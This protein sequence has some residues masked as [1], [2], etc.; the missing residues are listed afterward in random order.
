M[1]NASILASFI[2]NMYVCRF[3]QLM[4]LQWQR[5]QRVSFAFVCSI[6][7]RMRYMHPLLFLF[8]L[9]V[10][11]RAACV[12]YSI[13]NCLSIPSDWIHRILW[14]CQSEF[15]ML[16][17]ERVVT[18]VAASRL[19]QLSS[20]NFS[21]ISLLCGVELFHG[22]HRCICTCM[23][24]WV[25][26]CGKANTMLRTVP[27]NVF[28]SFFCC[29]VCLLD[30]Q[31][32]Y[33]KFN[34]K[35]QNKNCDENHRKAQAD[36]LLKNKKNTDTRHTTRRSAPS[37]ATMPAEREKETIFF[38]FSSVCTFFTAPN[39]HTHT[40]EMLMVYG[41]PFFLSMFDS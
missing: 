23:R 29:F 22:H 1:K 33:L 6:E 28:V 26:K 31:K 41:V 34:G 9:S 24:E 35:T 39:T 8:L 40:N 18:A 30:T 7:S 37:T 3:L 21:H 36:C 15:R 20:L 32:S 38:F 25:Y 27:F 14:Q 10:Q 13:E 12:C 2:A 11:A 19:P 5:R 16:F 17:A 4:E